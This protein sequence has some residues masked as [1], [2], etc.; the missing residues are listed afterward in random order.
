M[1]VTGHYIDENGFIKDCLIDLIEITSYAFLIKDNHTGVNL[2]NELINSFSVKGLKFENIGTITTD[3]A[4][5]N[6]TLIKYLK[7]D[8]KAVGKIG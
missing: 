1:A 7:K 3:N 4:A 8:M 6:K 2:A 5:N